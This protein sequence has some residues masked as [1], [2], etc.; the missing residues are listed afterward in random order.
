MIAEEISKDVMTEDGVTISL[1]QYVLNQGSHV[2]A[3]LTIKNDE[4]TE[5]K[6]NEIQNQ[7]K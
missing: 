1:V 3:F 4:P 2:S 6:C 7:V 5:E